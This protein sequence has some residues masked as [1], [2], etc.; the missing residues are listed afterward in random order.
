[1]LIRVGEVVDDSVRPDERAVGVVLVIALPEFA[2]AGG[3]E[4]EHKKRA[5]RRRHCHV[6]LALAKTAK[7]KA[8]ARSAPCFAQRDV[9][10]VGCKLSRSR[11][12]PISQTDRQTVLIWD[13]N[14]HTPRHRHIF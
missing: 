6:P 9:Y 1:M 12:H 8:S 4:E 2:A 7:L 5:L 11:A 13:T 3:R 10:H 14:P